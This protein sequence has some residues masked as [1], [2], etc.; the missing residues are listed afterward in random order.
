ME[1][2]EYDYTQC[3]KALSSSSSLQRCERNNGGKLY[4]SKQ[5]GEAFEHMKD[6]TVKKNLIFN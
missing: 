4:E 6:H 5:C 2:Y 3:I 1:G